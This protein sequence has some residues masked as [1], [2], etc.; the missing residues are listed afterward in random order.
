[1]AK[2]TG[3]DLMSRLDTEIENLPQLTSSFAD[4]ST[5]DSFHSSLKLGKLNEI[6]EPAGKVRVVGITDIWTQSLLRPLHDA[7]FRLLRT[8]KTDGTFDQLAPIRRLYDR[9][10][11][12]F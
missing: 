3:S 2:T 5:R 11:S 6:P 1:V 9:G 8:I 10:H 4:A 7:I 12:K